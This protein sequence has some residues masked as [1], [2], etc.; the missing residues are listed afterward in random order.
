ML[1]QA[2][3]SEAMQLLWTLADHNP[4]AVTSL[5]GCNLELGERADL[6]GS[7]WRS[8]L[9]SC[10]SLVPAPVTLAH[11]ESP[12]LTYAGCLAAAYRHVGVWQM[13]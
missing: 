5:E 12:Y 6:E 2:L 4:A 11:A 13:E 10:G 3:G 9:V 1:L 8:V 7:P